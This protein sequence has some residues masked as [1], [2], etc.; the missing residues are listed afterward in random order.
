MESSCVHGVVLGT[1]QIPVLMMIIIMMMMLLL[2]NRVGT[3]LVI[4]LIT[5]L[6]I[7][8]FRRHSALQSIYLSVC[9]SV[10]LYVFHSVLNRLI[11]R[12]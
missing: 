4:K 1:L 3:M 7:P 12:N 11:L 2:Y 5:L 8:P 10:C 9:L 6:R